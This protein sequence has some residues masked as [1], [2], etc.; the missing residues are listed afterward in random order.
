MHLY[1]YISLSTLGHSEKPNHGPYKVRARHLQRIDNL[2][3][4]PA[5]IPRT[6]AARFLPLREQEPVLLLGILNSQGQ[7]PSAAACG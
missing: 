5:I 2:E 1:S 6:F 3:T 4:S 7:P